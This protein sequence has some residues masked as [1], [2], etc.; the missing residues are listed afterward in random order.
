MHVL[1]FLILFSLLINDLIKDKLESITFNSYLIWSISFLLIL[2]NNGSKSWRVGLIQLSYLNEKQ[3]ISLNKFIKLS[4]RDFFF[5]F[6]TICVNSINNDVLQSL[7]DK[8][9]LFI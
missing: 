3:Y 4:L 1:C 6:D 7:F 2:I 8:N 5:V 9:T